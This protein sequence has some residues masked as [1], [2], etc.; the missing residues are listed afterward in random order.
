MIP[1]GTDSPDGGARKTLPLNLGAKAGGRVAAVRASGSHA[2]S[3]Y[4]VAWFNKGRSHTTQVAVIDREGHKLYKK[5]TRFVERPRSEWVAVPVSLGAVAPVSRELVEA[6]RHAIRNNRLPSNAGH[7]FWE[8]SG[9]GILRCA[10]CGGRAAPHTSKNR[11]EKRHY[12]YRCVNRW[13]HKS[14]DHGKNHRAADLE[15]EVWEVVSGAMKDPEQLRVD[16]DAM[17]ELQRSSG[18]LGDPE[19]EAA[20][21]LEKLTEVGRKRGAYQ[22]QQAEGLITLDEL[23]SKLAGLEET[24]KTAEREL[25]AL[26]GRQ[27][28]IAELEADRDDLLES[29]AEIAPDALDS[30]TAEQ[31]QRFYALLRIEILLAPDGSFEVRGIAFPGGLRSVCE[32]DTSRVW[33]SR[34][35][36]W[37]SRSRARS[38]RRQSH[39]QGA[40]DRG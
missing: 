3:V 38:S 14:C 27:E 24:R 23:R 9:G 2:D 11:F 16:L 39:G 5:R 33:I 30:L 36:R 19:R 12:Y 40:G 13:Q 28:Q 7:R 35:G 4:G 8:L 32:I 22:D 21:W 18:R 34:P 29:Y 26:R 37:I 20:A 10:L 17:I 6:A 25:E 1:I 15:A 31:R